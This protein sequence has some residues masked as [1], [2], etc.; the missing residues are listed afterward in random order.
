MSVVIESLTKNLML[1]MC[2]HRNLI[3]FY[4]VKLLMQITMCP[5]VYQKLFINLFISVCVLY[6]SDLLL[7]S[8][9]GEFLSQ[10][11]WYLLVVT[12]VIYLLLQHLSRRRSLQGDSSL[13]PLSQQGQ[14]PDLDARCNV[15]S[16][17]IWF[18]ISYLYMCSWS[19]N[20]LL[21][22]SLLA[23]FL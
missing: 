2:T 10:Y 7:F 19:R 20:A 12:I 17:E 23:T 14:Q 15:F 4:I 1:A 16:Y 6:A 9:A 22:Q 13:P 21:L 5:T 11:G 8:V 3:V 18:N